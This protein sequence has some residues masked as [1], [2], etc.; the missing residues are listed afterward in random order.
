MPSKRPSGATARAV[1]TSNLPAIFSILV[2][3][4]DTR[5]CMP[6]LCY[7][8][9]QKFGA[10]ATRFDQG[11]PTSTSAAMTIPG[12]PAPEPISIQDAFGSPEA[13]ELRRVDDV[14]LP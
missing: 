5:G 13:D 6:V 7:R 2:V 10:E 4:I 8:P 11:D 1:I 9:V 3:R 14:A 12:S